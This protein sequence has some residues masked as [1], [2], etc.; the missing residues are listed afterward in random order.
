MSATRF[1]HETQRQR[2]VFGAGTARTRLAGEVAALGGQRVLVVVAQGEVSIAEPL[3]AALPVAGRFADVR[4]HVPIAAAEAACEAAQNAAADLL[5]SVGGGST[6]G[7]AKAVALETGLPILAVPTTYAGSEATPVWGR[8]ESHRKTTGTDPRVLPRTIVY[9]PEL[10]ASLPVELS[11]ASGLN[12]VAHCVDSLWGP[13]A[14]PILDAMAAE[15]IRVLA[16]AL[17]RIRVDGADMDARG[18]CLCGAYLSAATFAGAGSGLHHKICH[19]L[20]GA[21]DLPHA[22]THA[23][24]LPHVLAFNADDAPAAAARVAGALGAVDAVSGLTALYDDLGPPR[25]LRDLGMPAEMIEEAAGLV[26]D[27]APPDNP[28]PVTSAAIERLLRRAWAGDLPLTA[29][30]DDGR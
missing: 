3:I 28:R 2:V 22:Q 21:Y 4:P 7:T 20:G 23:V 18:G 12:A 8:T 27:A 15:G 16:A 6:T 30:Q 11:I 19:V 5:L 17:R 1:E 24:V 13:R 29:T 9:D 25:A 10:S 26:A 14:N